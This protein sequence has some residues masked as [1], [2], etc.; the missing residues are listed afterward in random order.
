MWCYQ[1]KFIRYPFIVQL[2][3]QVFVTSLAIQ[4]SN[5]RFLAQAQGGEPNRLARLLFQSDLHVIV[6]EPTISIGRIGLRH[7]HTPPAF[8]Y[9]Q[10]SKQ[11]KKFMIYDDFAKLAIIGEYERR[12]FVCSANPT[13]KESHNHTR[14]QNIV[15]FGPR[16]LSGLQSIWKMHSS[17]LLP[18]LSYRRLSLAHWM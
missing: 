8:G 7:L 15:E 12:V 16:Q 10:A 1:R 9:V 18:T 17:C 4:C 6:Y 5:Y 11:A 2:Y 14:K 3:F 13:D